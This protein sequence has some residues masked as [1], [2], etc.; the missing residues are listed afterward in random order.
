MPEPTIPSAKVPWDPAQ[1]QG[2][3]CS[4]CACYFESI[5]AENPKEFQGF[6]RRQPADL[7][8]VRT[9]IPRL[10]AKGQA[11]VRDGQPVMNSAVIPGFL[12]KV[13]QREGT[14]FDGWREKGTL[15]GAANSQQQLQQ[16][17]KMLEQAMLS[18]LPSAG[19]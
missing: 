12:F 1:L 16:L 7:I 2:R 19:G 11:V 4:A 8:E 18:V 15:P 10:D 13:A 6:C 14:C 3:T 17:R 9:Q 5:N